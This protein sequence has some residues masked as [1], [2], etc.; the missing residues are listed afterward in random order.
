MLAEMDAAADRNGAPVTIVEDR[1]ENGSGYIYGSQELLALLQDERAPVVG[2]DPKWGFMVDGVPGSRADRARI[3]YNRS[4]LNPGGHDSP[5][6][7]RALPR[8]GSRL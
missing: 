4:Q 8:N 5:A 2:D 3:E 1:Q 6:H 7:R